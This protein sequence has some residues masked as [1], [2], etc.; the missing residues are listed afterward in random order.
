MHPSPLFHGGGVDPL[1]KFSKSGGRGGLGRHFFFR[2]G[3]VGKSEV[4]LGGELGC[5]FYI[6]NKVKSEIRN[7]KNVYKQKV[8]L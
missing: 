3:L 2:G 8:F 6:K 4:G 5:N 1:A 7:D